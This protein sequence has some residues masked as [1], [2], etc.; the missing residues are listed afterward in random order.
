L[1]INNLHRKSDRLL[2]DQN[3]EEN[4]NIQTSGKLEAPKLNPT[5]QPAFFTEANQLAPVG[6][7]AF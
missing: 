5:N 3:C 6:T 2:G 1:Q 7:G 4:F